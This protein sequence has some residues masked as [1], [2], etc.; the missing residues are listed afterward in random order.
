MLCLAKEARHKSAQLHKDLKQIKFYAD[1]NHNSG[2][3]VENCLKSVQYFIWADG[4]F[5]RGWWS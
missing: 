2:W 4:N 3:E 1:T 5:H